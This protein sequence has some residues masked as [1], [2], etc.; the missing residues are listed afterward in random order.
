MRF[1]YTSSEGY[2]YFDHKSMLFASLMSSLNIRLCFLVN[3]AEGDGIGSV[4]YPNYCICIYTYLTNS[5]IYVIV[6]VIINK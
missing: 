3:Y 6:I 4:L 5:Y 2:F 1:N